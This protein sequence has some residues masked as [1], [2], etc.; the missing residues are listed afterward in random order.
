MKPLTDKKFAR[1]LFK[2][3]DIDDGGSIS[4]DEMTDILT[5][6]YKMDS[7]TNQESCK[8]TELNRLQS[9]GSLG[10]SDS[11]DSGLS[12]SENAL[13]NRAFMKE[14]VLKRTIFSIDFAHHRVPWNQE[15]VNEIFKVLDEDGNDELDQEEFVKILT[16][17]RHLVELLGDKKR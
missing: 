12:N 10:S 3:Y 7:N 16:T 17:D 2:L 6:I 9:I 15:K 8:N 13:K 14:M 5:V 4:R 11:S 1:K